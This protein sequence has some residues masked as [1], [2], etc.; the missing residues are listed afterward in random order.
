[1][2]TPKAYHG[3]SLE[4]RVHLT[5]LPFLFLSTCWHSSGGPSFVLS[6]AIAMSGPLAS[7]LCTLAMSGAFQEQQRGA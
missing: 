5:P 6:V 1:M 2:T 7:T 3:R 4:R